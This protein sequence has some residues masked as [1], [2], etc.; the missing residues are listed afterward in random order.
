MTSSDP[1]WLWQFL[2]RLHPL[3]VHFPIGLLCVAL[4]AELLTGRDKADSSRPVIRVLLWTGTVSALLAVC[5]GWMLAE[6]EGSEGGIIEIHR[7]AGIATLLLSS[8]TLAA[9][10]YRSRG[11]YLALLATT[12]AGVTVAGHYGAMITHGEDYLTSVLP[13]G[14]DGAPPIADEY[15][16]TGFSLASLD[17]TLTPTQVQDLNLEVRTI[18]AHSCYSCHG[19][20]KKKGG[21][22]LDSKDAIFA[23]GESGPVIVAG[24]PGK[25]ELIR[26][27]TLPAGHKEVMPSKGKLLTG[28]E[29]NV[30]K[31]WIEK[32]APWP[33]GKEKSVY[34][35]AE[36]APR[37][38]QIPPATAEFTQPIDRF[39]NAYFKDHGVAWTDPVNDRIYIRRVYLDVIGLLPE[40]AK[41]EQFEK[42][43][44]PDKR[45]KLVASLLKRDD[46]YAQHWLT[47]WNDLLRNDYSGTGYITGGRFDITKWLYNSLYDNKPYNWFVKELVS[48]GKESAGFIKGIKWRGTIN[49]SQSTQMQAAQNVAQVFLGLNLKCA[50]CHDSFISDWKLEDAYG[51]AN[52]FADST[53]EVHRCDQPTGKMAKSRM[54]Y[55][56]LGEISADAATEQRLKELAEFLAQP[57]DG[58]LYRTLVNRIWAQLMG[59]GIVEPVDVMDNLPWSQD[60]LDWLAYD[61]AESGYDI[62]RLLK[63]ILTS[64]TYQ[65]RSVTVQDPAELVSEKFKFSGMVRRRISAEQFADAVSRAF[66]PVY[67]DS[68]M[69]LK[70]LPEDIRARAPFPRASLVINDKFQTA[71]GRPNRETVS[72]GRTS[73]AN[74]LQ[75]LELTNGTTFYETLK[76]GS[77]EWK[78]KFPDSKQLIITLY[79]RAYGRAPTPEEL[80]VALKAV[81]EKPEESG[82]QDMVWA[83]ALSPEFQ[84]IL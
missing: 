82:I 14:A 33:E 65:L 3:V 50:S 51:F 81:G 32:G 22:R 58:R 49:S 27:V 62:K 61:F 41:I 64:K 6:H 75:A 15:N 13:M 5:F 23:G 55:P 70:R 48:P 10:L 47:F 4:L 43:N 84:L 69:A 53:L 37:L 12:V 63:Q 34:R 2:G 19:E 42:D 71:L 46:D 17:E 40:P 79:Q 36:L 44:S 29:V 59:R 60:L 26:R 25:S 39:V 80:S 57:Q 77:K 7:W 67:A 9:F 28:N 38:P 73:Q 56:E 24:N 66:H 76:A 74:L 54:L 35:V 16:S 68:V 21:L 8:F 20:A 52:I 1:F 83:I 45:E 78:E 30:L 31:V 11:T 72:T 18:L